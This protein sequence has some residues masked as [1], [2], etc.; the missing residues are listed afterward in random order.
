MSYQQMIK[1]LENAFEQNVQKIRR[2]KVFGDSGEKLIVPVLSGLTGIG[3]TSAIKEFTENKKFK[4]VSID[5]SF[6][7]ADSIIIGLNNAVKSIVNEEVEGIV[8]WLN[9]IDKVTEENL[10][11]IRQ[12]QKNYLDTFITAKIP[13]NN[14]PIHTLDSKKIKI[15]Y[16]VLPETLII[17]GEQRPE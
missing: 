2:K 3:K 7:E 17:I 10:K 11:T 12:Y 13:E 16:D 8:L 1:T 6:E 9:Y 5:C 14:K 4:L 15:V